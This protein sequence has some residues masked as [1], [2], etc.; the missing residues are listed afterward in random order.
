MTGLAP[1]LVPLLVKD[2]AVKR[3]RAKLRA[4]D[5]QADCITAVRGVGYKFDA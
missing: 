5:P 4:L 1:A 2:S 3:L